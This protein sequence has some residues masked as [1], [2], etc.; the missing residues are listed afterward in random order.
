MILAE[1]ERSRQSVRDS[2]D[3]KLGWGSGITR[4]EAWQKLDFPEK[5]EWLLG[6]ILIPIRDH[7]L[8]IW[9]QNF[10]H[11]DTAVPWTG[12][13]QSLAEIGRPLGEEVSDLLRWTLHKSRSGVAL[14]NVIPHVWS[15]V[16]AQVPQW[17]YHLVERWPLDLDPEELPA[18]APYQRTAV[19][20]AAEA[21]LYP[22][23]KVAFTKKAT[24]GCSFR[25]PGI[26][27]PHMID[28]AAYGLWKIG[29]SDQRLDEFFA[30]VGGSNE[31]TIRTLAKWVCFDGDGAD[32]GRLEEVK[33]ALDPLAQLLGLESSEGQLFVQVAEEE[34]E[35]LQERLSD[36]R[37]FRLQSQEERTVLEQLRSCFRMDP[38][39]LLFPAALVGE[40]EQ[41]MLFN[42]SLT[43]HLLIM[44]G[45]SES[46][47][48][49]M[50]QLEQ[51]G[52]RVV[53]QGGR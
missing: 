25:C 53:R 5:V 10:C 21:P 24:D 14:S 45:G 8:H 41:A 9:H 52:T 26:S 28:T 4:V 6:E 36:Y 11:E 40:E 35:E 49:L 27:L 12:I 33:K 32:R 29:A 34:L 2:V 19:E 48:A 37:T 51:A 16:W 20:P 39:I 13:Y 17:A 1:A 31:Q 42:A 50:T 38:D 47:E 3:E 18:A 44:G 22:E 15:H 43:G 23:C 7:R 30:E 46:G